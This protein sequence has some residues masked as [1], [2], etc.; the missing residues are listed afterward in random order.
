[1]TRKLADTREDRASRV[2]RSG[3]SLLTACCGLALSTL[4]GCSSQHTAVDNHVKPL[5]HT[6]RGTASF[7]ANSPTPATQPSADTAPGSATSTALATP[8]PPPEEPKPAL[9]Q[10]CSEQ[11]SIVVHKAARRLELRCGG[12]LAAEFDVSLGFA[13]SGAKR[14]EGDGKTPEGDYFVTGNWASQFHRSLQISYP[15]ERDAVRGLAEGIITQWQHDAIVRAHRACIQPPQNTA[16]G[17]LIQVHGAGGGP[18]AGDWT[19]GCVALDNPHI[20]TVAAFFR[21]GCDG[22]KPRTVVKLRP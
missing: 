22:G 9:L 2:R 18:D 10:S 12:E 6:A 14:R 4:I 17:S 7:L 5:S 11:R 8:T 15:N 13:P 21:P 20:D 1:M 19:L 16:L 3:L